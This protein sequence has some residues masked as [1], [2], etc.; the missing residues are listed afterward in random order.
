MPYGGHVLFCIC[1]YD[2]SGV[3]FNEQDLMGWSTY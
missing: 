2:L 1:S 3:L